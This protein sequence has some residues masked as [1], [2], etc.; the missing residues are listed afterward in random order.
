MSDSAYA[1]RAAREVQADTLAPEL[2]R[3][4]NEW[5]FKARNE[6]QVRNFGDARDY[7]VNARKFAEEAEFQA[8][9]NGAI[10]QDLYGLSGQDAESID[11]VE[12]GAPSPTP[13]ET[14]TVEE[15]DKRQNPQPT[16]EKR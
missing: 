10:R 15:Y 16:P 6:Y 13:P 1:I 12:G 9:K 14:V 11:V 5:Y 8:L 2:Y 4:A 3:K 7:A